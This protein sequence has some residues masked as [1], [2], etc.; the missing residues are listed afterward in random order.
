MAEGRLDSNAQTK[1]P[2]IY[3]PFA[4]FPYARLIRWGS[5]GIQAAPKPPRLR[6]VNTYRL[7]RAYLARLSFPSCPF[8]PAS[9]NSWGSVNRYGG[10]SHCRSL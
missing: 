10:P 7:R 2:S 8:L 4:A 5:L 9:S 1:Q 6:G 3:S